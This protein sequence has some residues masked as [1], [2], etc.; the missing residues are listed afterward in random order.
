MYPSVTGRQDSLVRRDLRNFTVRGQLKPG[1]RM[2]QARADLSAL[3]SALAAE[4]PETNRNRDLS[5]RTETEARIMRS[6]I[7]AMITGMLLTMA[8]AVLLVACANVGGLLTSRTPSRAREIAVRMAV[9]AGRFRLIRQLM[10]EGL[11][12]ALS[13]GALG[14]VVGYGG[15]KVFQQIRVPSDLGG[16]DFPPYLDQRLLMFSLIVALVST[17]LFALLPALRATRIDVI[18]AAKAGDTAPG[19]R[20]PRGRSLLVGG[21]VAVA[22]LLLTVATFL[23]R[24]F[25]QELGAGLGFRTD[26]VLK[27]GFNPSLVR[28]NPEQTKKFYKEL[29]Q[30]TRS[31]PGVTSAT[32]TSQI[33]IGLDIDSATI[34]P[35]GHQFPEGRDSVTV[36]ASRVDEAYFQTMGIGITAGRGFD[37]SDSEG[38]PRVAIVN[39]ALA[40]HYWPGQSPIGKRFRMGNPTGPW[41]EIVGVAQTHKYIWIG[42][43]TTEYLYLPHLQNPRQS[44]TLLVESAGEPQNM[45]AP[46]REVV[47]RLDPNQ[48]VFDVLTMDE[49]YQMRTV[50]NFNV[51]IGTIGAMGLMG[52]GLAIVGLYG[53]M[54]YSISRRTR[55]IG[56]RIAIGADRAVVLKMILKQSAILTLCGLGAGLV[57][58]LLAARLLPAIFPAFREPDIISFLLVMPTLLAVTMLAAFIPAR[59]ASRMDPT[60][61]LRYE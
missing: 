17:L 47:R 39:E 1:V 38:T 19:L 35:E 45:A 27:M 18:Q 3:A 54:A 26:H 8:G 11:L 43:G 23:H 6:P 41:V 12:L 16:G 60:V 28:Y 22:L 52:L 9:G 14:L 2:A 29:L 59:R 44:M 46:L 32:L 24:A 36:A 5:V 7:D 34:V 10:V 21:Q 49:F 61:A 48:P 33:P 20:G 55:E 56:I 4:Y 25:Q 31:T 50:T 51:L 53:L 37:A 57:L 30:Q 15:I 42:E 58:S 13:G 40:R